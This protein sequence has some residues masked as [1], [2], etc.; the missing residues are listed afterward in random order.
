MTELPVEIL[1]PFAGYLALGMYHDA[2]DELENLPTVLKAHPTVLS[3]R[4]DL[5]IE[6]KRWE[7]GAILGSSLFKLWPE[8]CEHYV[9]TAFCLHEM[10]QTKE[11][12]KTLLGAP[13]ALR[14]QAV[15][16]YNMACY[17]A[18]LGNLAE[19]RRYLD[20]CFEMDKNYRAES[21]DDLD[22]APLWALVE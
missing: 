3:A 16:Y 21:L 1:E 11:A 4:L 14:D 5:L 10:K 20:I 15:Y 8:E 18:Q 17:E 9:R 2:N 13:E 6:M 22:L 19:A 7:D 12:R